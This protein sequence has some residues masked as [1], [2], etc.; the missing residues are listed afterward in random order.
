MK[1]PVLGLLLGLLVIGLGTGVS[2]RA[3][4]AGSAEVAEAAA[5]EMMTPA[6]ERAAARGLNYLAA[7]QR[8][9]GSFGSGAYRGNVAVTAL[10]GMAFL[11]EGS[12]PNRGPHGDV[13]D[14]ALQYILGQCRENGLILNPPSASRGPMYEHG[15]AT[16]FLAECLGSTPRPDLREKLAAAAA[17]IVNTQNAEGGWRYQPQKLDADIS[18]TVCQ[19]MALRA[20]RNAGLHVPKE[21]VE[22]CI[23]Y[24]RR[25]QNPDGGFR[26]MLIPGESG[27][28]RSAAGVVALY[29]AGIYEGPEIENGIRYLLDFVPQRGGLRQEPYYFYGHYYAVQ[30]MWQRGGDAW[31]RYYPAIRDELIRRQSPDGSWPD[32]ISPEYGTAM[33]CLILQVPNGYLPIFER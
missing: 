30:A 7:R 10:V 28:A 32:P 2:A 16:L 26:Y 25:S 5:A 31:L 3:E 15:F 12:L 27:F 29:S 20:A 8:E 13:T 1:R 21:T 33:A 18:V 19:I 17:L 22:R 14:R 11:S 24:V 4:L 6:A 9:D 23:D